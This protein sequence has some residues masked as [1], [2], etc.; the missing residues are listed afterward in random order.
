MPRRNGRRLTGVIAAS[1]ALHL[2]LFALLALRPAASSLRPYEE[3]AIAVS[4]A[5]LYLVE[6][7]PRA[8]SRQVQAPIRPR[9]ARRP[10]DD[11]AVAPL[12][13]GPSS[14]RAASGGAADVGVGAHPAT[15]PPGTTAELGRALRL[16]G[17]GC[18]APNLVGMTQAERDRCDERL[19]AGA[20]AAAYLGQ[21][22]SR[23]KQRQLDQ[24]NA[25]KEAYRKYRDGP[26]PPGLSGSDA[27]GG[28]TGLGDSRPTGDHRY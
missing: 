28:L 1:A 9:Q 14:G 27:A 4:L 10:A 6:P 20:K 3:D 5:P 26:M 24:A 12:Y 21:G 23:E 2:G 19:G 25:R 11:T 8:R 15:Q 17:V 22:L 16:G 13:A 7:T 18:E